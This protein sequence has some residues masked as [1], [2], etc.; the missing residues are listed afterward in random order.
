MILEHKSAKVFYS[1]YGT[2]KPVVLLHGFLENT[3][4]WDNLVEDLSA[5]NQVIC[6]DLLG[7][8]Q[9]DCLGYVHTM[10]D[11]SQAVNSVLNYL[12]IYSYKIIGHSLGG[13]VALALAEIN[14][15]NIEGLCLMNSTPKAD[16]NE[17]VSLRNRA[18]KT[19]KTHYE[20]LVSMS[21]SNLFYQ[22]NRNT[23]SKDIECLKSE[24]LKTP[25]QGY[26]AAQ[27]GMKIRPDK[28]TFFNNASFKKYIIAGEKDPVLDFNDLKEIALN[29][30]SEFRAMKGG[31]MS[32]IEDLPDL[33]LVLLQFI[34]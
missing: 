14:Q 26:I 3:T 4:M 16:T 23:F 20:S 15:N 31:H 30:N 7:H 9:S 10:K 28:T 6:I 2:G 5:K 11:F 29:S 32:Q 33:K 1:V 18:I 12:N 8:G 25:I 34:N 19:A 21:I 17:R 13:Y 27:E 24:A 22:N